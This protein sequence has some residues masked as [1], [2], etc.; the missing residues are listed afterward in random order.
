MLKLNKLKNFD[1][2]NN[3][4]FGGAGF[5]GSHLVDKLIENDENVLCIDNL[6]SGNIENINQSSTE[7]AVGA[8]QTAQSSIELS[9][10][11]ANLHSAMSQFRVS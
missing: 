5:L 10:L 11:A 1:V 8:N 4:V 2:I 9:K 7:V 3:I 6:S